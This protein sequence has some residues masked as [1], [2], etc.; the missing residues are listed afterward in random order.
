MKIG[1]VGAGQFATNFSRMFNEHPL[2]SGV[3]I[4]DILPARAAELK[5]RSNLSGTFE[6][7]E[8]MLKSDIDAVVIMTQ[9]WTHHEFVI[10]A[11]RAGKHVYS[12]V[13]MA[14]TEEQ[15]ASIIETVKETGL[16]YML[17]ETSYYNAAIV[18]AREK[19]AKAGKF[20]RLFYAEGDYVHD[21]HNGFYAAYQFSGGEDWKKG[22]SFPPMLYPTHSLGGVLGVWNTHGVSVSALGSVDDLGDGVFDKSVSMFD[23][24][25][26]NMTA[27]IETADGGMIRIN[28]F[29]R[30]GHPATAHESRFRFYGTDGVMEQHNHSATFTDRENE[31]DFSSEIT[32]A[33]SVEHEHI[34]GLDPKLRQSFESG[35]APIH[36]AERLPKILNSLPNGHEGS[37]GFLA[38]DFVRSV[39]E[40]KQP[41]LNAWAAARINLPGIIALESARRGGERLPIKDFGPCPFE[42]IEV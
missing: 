30:V 19:L 1:I 5:E 7:F 12:A 42:V 22:A 33:P 17:G 38:D 35:L 21:M 8:E 2:V 27:L 28:E 20:G 11:L 31:Y 10:K 14:T 18:Y 25:F 26:S 39:V 4:T 40:G 3:Y 36:N 24:D 37:H 6:S 13:P 16:S 29:R 9:R 34:E 15:I 41:I 32:C 23:N